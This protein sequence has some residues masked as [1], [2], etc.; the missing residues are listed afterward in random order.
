MLAEKCD[1]RAIRAPDNVLHRRGS[2]LGKSLLL[3]NV[4]QDDGRRRAE[5]QARSAAVEDLVRSNGRLDGLDDRVRE[6]AHLDQLK[7]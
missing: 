1:E 6:V 4:V 5:D 2:D 3:L 7:W